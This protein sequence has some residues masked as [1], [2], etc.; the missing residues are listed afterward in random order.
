MI[1]CLFTI[2]RTAVM[3]PFKV[4]P[5]PSLQPATSSWHSL[6]LPAGEL[7]LRWHRFLRVQSYSLQLFIQPLESIQH[8]A[9]LVAS[10]AL[11]QLTIDAHG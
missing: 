1:E 8:A 7:R 10:L 11:Y 3:A 4:S 6:A 5:I 9:W 2:L